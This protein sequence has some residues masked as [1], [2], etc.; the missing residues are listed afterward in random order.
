MNRTIPIGVQVYGVAG[1]TNVLHTAIAEDGHDEIWLQATGEE[2][3]IFYFE[4]EARHA[5]DWC[6][7]HG[8]QY[9]EGRLED[10][11]EL[12]FIDD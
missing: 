5:Y 6:R 3:E 2:G 11:V 10:D 1:A 9:Y 4:A 7:E 8:F 12:Y